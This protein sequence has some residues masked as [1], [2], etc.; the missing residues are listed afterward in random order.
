MSYIITDESK[1]NYELLPQEILALKKE[2]VVLETANKQLKKEAETYKRAYERWSNHAVI[3][4]AKK[5][6]GRSS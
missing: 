4:L 5:I 3:R 1:V 2:I 6:A